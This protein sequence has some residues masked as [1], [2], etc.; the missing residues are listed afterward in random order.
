MKLLKYQE[1]GKCPKCGSESLEYGS[2]EPDSNS[3]KYE[4]KCMNCN[5]EGYEW[6]DLTYSES[7]KR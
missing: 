1:E 4:F 6:Y 5:F 3:L 2:S 7:T